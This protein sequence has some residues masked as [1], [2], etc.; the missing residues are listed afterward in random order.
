M[1]KR[2]FKKEMKEFYGQR[3]E[4]PS[5]VTIPPMNFITIEGQGDPNASKEYTEALN[6]LY[7]AAY[8]VKFMI[9][10]GREIDYGVM[11]LQGLWWADDLS[12]FTESHRDLWKWRM[13]IFQPEF[14]TREIFDTAIA[15]VRRKKNPRSLPKLRFESYDEGLC[16]QILHV[17][18]FTTEPA[19]ILRL[20]EFIGANGYRRRG[21]HHEI[22]LTNIERTAPAKWK[23][24]IRQPM[25]K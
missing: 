4:N 16:A 17:G 7:S 13:M 21:L 6:A 19:T 11:P 1:E 12:S 24:I 15:E 14:V 3:T 18:P 5:I 20:H 25:E 9:K 23:T 10:K 22:Y 8:T 2:D